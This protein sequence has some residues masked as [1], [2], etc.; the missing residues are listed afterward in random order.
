M[1]MGRKGR[2]DKCCRDSAVQTGAK[3]FDNAI[4][5]GTM[6]QC[7]GMLKVFPRDFRLLLLQTDLSQKAMHQ[8]AVI[9]RSKTAACGHQQVDLGRGKAIIGHIHHPF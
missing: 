3:I 6:L 7:S 2:A 8:T 5:V 9:L 1:D 4:H